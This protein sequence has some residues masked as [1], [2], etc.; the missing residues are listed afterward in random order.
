MCQSECRT[1]LECHV[2]VKGFLRRRSVSIEAVV[3][4]VAVLK[5]SPM[6]RLPQCHET[7]L[8]AAEC[9]SLRRNRSS[10][11]ARIVGRQ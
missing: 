3:G 8:P 10:Q 7:D 2:L 9:S 11:E 4:L 6:E 1:P 5:V